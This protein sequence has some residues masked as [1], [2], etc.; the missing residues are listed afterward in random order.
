MKIG[1]VADIHYGPD[2]DTQLGTQAPRMLESFREA[3]EAFRPDMIV[4]LGD[5]V[6]RV[7]REEDR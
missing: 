5:R 7:T 6:N 1:L 2:A 4:D 3:M